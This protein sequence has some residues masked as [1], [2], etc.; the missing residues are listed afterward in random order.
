M[1]A[2]QGGVGAMVEATSKEYEKRTRVLTD[3]EVEP[4]AQMCHEANRLYQMQN[5]EDPSP[6]WGSA[7]AWQRESA[8]TGVRKALDPRA[9]LQ[10]YGALSGDEEQHN[11]WMEEKLR[12]G[13]RY[14]IHK[15]AEA[16]T[17]PCLLPFASLPAWQRRKDGLFRAI[18]HALDPRQP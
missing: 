17:H 12:A 1:E 14:G 18:C 7:P 3:S 5:G 4:I 13:W 10:K 9:G 6:A 11:A 8:M 2:M 15:D 16:K